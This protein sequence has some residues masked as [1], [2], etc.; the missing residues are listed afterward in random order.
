M[1]IFAADDLA[2]RL[3]QINPKIIVLVGGPHI[4]AVPHE[5]MEKFPSFDIAAIGEAEETISDLLDTLEGK[6]NN[7]LADVNGIIFRENNHLIT[8]KPRAL[9]QDLDSLPLPAWDML[10]D[11]KK[12]YF[13]PAWT[14][15]SQSMT[16][17]T[18]RGC[19]YQC[20]YCDRKV[21]GNRIRYHSAKYVMEMIRL[22]NS[23]YGINH[24]RIG[25]DIFMIKKERM[26]KV[27]EMLFAEKMKVTWS[28][29]ARVDSIN[30]ETLARM[31]KA[32]CFSIAFGVETGSQKIHD[33]EKKKIK[34]SQIAE[35]VKI[36]RKAGIKT[37]SFNII[38]HPME[39]IE[40]IK[41]T[42]NFNKKIKVDEFKTQFMV[43]FPGTELYQIADKYGDF[44]KDW[45]RMTVFQEPIFIPHG[46]T[47]EEMIEWNK[48]G[49]MS[50]YL[51]PRIIFA[52]LRQI[53]SWEEVKMILLGGL[54]LIGWGL[55]E[56]LKI[57]MNLIRREKK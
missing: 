40:T 24:L 32:G 47:K 14:Q 29:L 5:T 3:K 6:K 16:I 26:L 53:R 55:R 57:P 12:Y 15:H 56:L 18:S 54:T 50:F 17:L 13:A 21:F 36:T 35:A 31:K 7:S 51:Q 1:D 34:L 49:F 48:K 30:P 45:R 52:Y 4:T 2:V 8:T 22:L 44:D 46:L 38:G 42:I 9:I 25:D 10:P 20:I 27:C 23:R 41:E 37:I 39:T 19:P 28:C 33:F 11:L 43:P